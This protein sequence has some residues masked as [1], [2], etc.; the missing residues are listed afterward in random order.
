[1]AQDEMGMRICVK[2]AAV[3]KIRVRISAAP[4][5]DAANNPQ[6]CGAYRCAAAAIAGKMTLSMISGLSGPTWRSVMV[7]VPSTTKVS[8]TP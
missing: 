2:S 8:G 6:N 5:F 3:E 4:A 7:P 1:M